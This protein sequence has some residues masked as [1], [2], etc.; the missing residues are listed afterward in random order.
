M[1]E[2][3]FC[4]WCIFPFSRRNNIDVRNERVWAKEHKQRRPGGHGQQGAAVP[5]PS[6][7]D[8]RRGSA[9]FVDINKIQWVQV[10]A[11]NVTL[12]KKK[13]RLKFIFCGFINS[14]YFP[15][16]LWSKYHPNKYSKSQNATFISPSA[17]MSPCCRRLPQRFG[18]VN[19]FWML[20]L[21]LLEKRVGL[22]TIKP[23][24]N[25]L[26]SLGSKLF[27]VW[28]WTNTD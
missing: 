1:N 26:F 5:S 28:T 24:Q 10:G 6:Q 23:K 17:G 11:F 7:S 18:P 4:V 3:S 14:S 2:T 13:Y 9:E 22:Q 25:C 15:A 8:C 19:M 21:F 20:K 27:A 12:L 16:A